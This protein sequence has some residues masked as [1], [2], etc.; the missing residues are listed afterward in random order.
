DIADP[1]ARYYTALRLCI[2]RPIGWIILMNP[3]TLIRLAEIGNDH[4]DELIRDLR[5][6]TLSSRFEIPDAIRH[7]LDRQIRRKQVAAAR[8]LEQIVERTGRLDPKDYWDR[9]VIGCW[10]GG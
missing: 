8:R 10:I 3:G 7:K 1:L 9:P 5:D 4:R 6:G 2:T